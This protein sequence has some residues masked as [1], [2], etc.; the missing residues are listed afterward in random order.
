METK[1]CT[2]CL[3]EKPVENFPERKE[4][5][6]TSRHSWCVPCYK[7][8]K[9]AYWLKNRDELIEKKKLRYN[10][11]PRRYKKQT[12]KYYRENYDSKLRDK[13]WTYKLKSEYG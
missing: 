4:K 8:Y 11:D 3:E 13:C 7:E 1:I 9:Q 10:E 6:R 5:G 12:Q 2:K